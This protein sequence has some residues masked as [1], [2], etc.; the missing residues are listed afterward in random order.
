MSI[1]SKYI[2]IDLAEWCTGVDVFAIKSDLE[3]DSKRNHQDIDGPIQTALDYV[4]HRLLTT[5]F[6]KTHPG[7]QFNPELLEKLQWTHAIALRT[8]HNLWLEAAQ[9]DQDHEGYTWFPY[10]KDEANAAIDEIIENGVLYNV[11]EDSTFE[12]H[13]VTKSQ[14]RRL[15][16]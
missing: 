9:G 8:Q 3:D 7:K 4:M 13:E 10:F 2:P 5:W 14:P 16:R 6:I 15:D 1:T 12:A 11:D